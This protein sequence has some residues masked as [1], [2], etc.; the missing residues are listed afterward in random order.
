MPGA[1]PP[2]DAKAELADLRSRL[3]E[4]E[5]YL[6]LERLRERSDELA[7]EVSRPDLWDDA[8][9]ARAV[10]TELGGLNDDIAHARGSRRRASPTQRFSTS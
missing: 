10:T 7:E 4:A 5:A 1:E 2:R 3:T 6:G 9:R 8:D